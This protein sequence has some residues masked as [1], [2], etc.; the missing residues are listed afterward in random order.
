MLAD[1]VYCSVNDTGIEVLSG[2]DWSNLE[3]LILGINRLILDDSIIGVNGLTH[4]LT[5]N[6]L[7]K[8]KKLNLSKNKLSDQGMAFLLSS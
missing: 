1:L 6:K 4:L 8:L 7:P 2:L 3:H 5:H